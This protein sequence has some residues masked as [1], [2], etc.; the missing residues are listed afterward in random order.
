MT[1]SKE[2]EEHK[3]EQEPLLAPPTQEELR[4]VCEKRG[5]HRRT[6]VLI[7]VDCGAI[8]PIPRKQESKKSKEIMARRIAKA[9]KA[10]KLKRA[11][12]LR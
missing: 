6:T 2:V 3:P 4:A 7:C 5:E 12:R 1:E 9:A 10:A 11:R 8:M